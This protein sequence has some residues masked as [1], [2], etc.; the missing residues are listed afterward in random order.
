MCWLNQENIKDTVE[1]DF[2]ETPKGAPRQS[3]GNF[4]ASREPRGFERSSISKTAGHKSVSLF[5][6]QRKGFEPLDSCPSTVFK[7]AAFDRSAISAFIL[8]CL[9]GAGECGAFVVSNTQC[10]R[11]AISAFILNCFVARQRF[12]AIAEIPSTS[13]FPKL[14]PIAIP[15]HKRSLQDRRVVPN[16]QCYR[17]DKRNNVQQ[18]YFSKLYLPC[19]TN[20]LLFA[21][22]QK[23]LSVKQIITLYSNYKKC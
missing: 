17:S 23:I 3:V 2:A 4:V 11:S 1:R 19:Q 7:T 5:L 20:L 12:D 16:T 21:Q 22:L 15:S 13:L 6:A 10:Y 14:R 9:L 8:N 18:H